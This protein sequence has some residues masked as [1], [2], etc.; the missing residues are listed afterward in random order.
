MEIISKYPTKPTIY[1]P[2]ASPNKCDI[3]ICHEFAID[4]RCGTIISYKM[5]VYLFIIM[6]GISGIKLSLQLFYAFFTFLP[7]LLLIFS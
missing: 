5:K 7:V 4:R 2:E 6:S 3:S 1:G